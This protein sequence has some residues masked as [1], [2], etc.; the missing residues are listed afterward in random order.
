MQI[1]LDIIVCS[2]GD[3]DMVYNGARPDPYIICDNKG[4]N[5][6]FSSTASRVVGSHLNSFDAKIFSDEGED[7]TDQYWIVKTY[8][9]LNITPRDIVIQ[10]N[11]ASKVYD[12]TPL[13]CDEYTILTDTGSLVSGHTVAMCIID[14]EQTDIGRSQNL[15]TYI[16]ILDENRKDVT[17]NYWIKYLSGTL[18]VTSK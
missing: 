5:I 7:I 9:K 4:L 6:E 11:D 8:G 17:S 14:G 3:C 12:G 18:R 10:A 15:I 13:T 16:L 2:S 1:Y